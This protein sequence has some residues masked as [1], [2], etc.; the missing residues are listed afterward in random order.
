MEHERGN[1]DARQHVANVQPLDRLPERERHA[2]AHRRPLE[3]SPESSLYCTAGLRRGE[4]L[5]R[6]SFAPAIDRL[7]NAQRL[8]PDRLLHRD[9]LHHRPDRETVVED[10]TGRAL[11]MAGG[12][13]S[14]ESGALGEAQQRGPLGADRVHHRTDVV[15]SFV[16]GRRS[17]DGIR[18]SRAALVEHDQPRAA[19]QPTEKARDRRLGPLEVEVREP[20]PHIHE[21]EWTLAQDL[22]G[23]VRIAALRVARLGSWHGVPAPQA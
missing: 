6:L 3:H 10:Q 7:P 16:E 4:P 14:A 9:P 17:G 12:E 2:R 19:R 5:H 13:K 8:L 22:V 20:S 21:V 15:H 1:R 11:G 23:D 18:K